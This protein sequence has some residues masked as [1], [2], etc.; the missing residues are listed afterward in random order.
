MTGFIIDGVGNATTASLNNSNG[1]ITTG[2]DGIDCRFNNLNASGAITGGSLTDGTATLSSG[3]LSG[4]TNIALGRFDHG[5]GYD[6]RRRH[7]RYGR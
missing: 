5:Y 4:A 3:A 7:A 1:G 2:V 6:D